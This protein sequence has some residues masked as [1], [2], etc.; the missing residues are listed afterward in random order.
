MR[1]VTALYIMVWYQAHAVTALY[2]SDGSSPLRYVT[3]GNDGA[4]PYSTSGNAV[5]APYRT[6]QALITLC[7]TAR[8]LAG[9]AIRYGTGGNGPLR[10]GTLQ[11]VAALCTTA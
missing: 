4:M 1:A 8:M 5:T 6:S 2:G 11:A 7:G 9:S 3:G 10:H